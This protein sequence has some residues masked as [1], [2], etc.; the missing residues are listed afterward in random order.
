MTANDPEPPDD[1][2]LPPVEIDWRPFIKATQ[3]AIDAYVFVDDY[4]EEEKE[5]SERGTE[6]M[7]VRAA[8]LADGFIVPGT[9]D[10]WMAHIG[11]I[12]DNA[13]TVFDVIP[14]LRYLAIVAYHTSR[15]TDLRGRLSDQDPGSIVR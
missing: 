11:Q 15:E 10:E 3:A 2:T 13:R 14:L 4:T 9:T 6:K 5:K 12:L 8:L 7:A 1:P